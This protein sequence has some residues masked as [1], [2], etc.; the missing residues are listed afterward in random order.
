[1][2]KQSLLI[3]TLFFS[4]II[5]INTVCDINK[6]TNKKTECLKE[7]SVD[8]YCCFIKPLEDPTLPSKCYPYKIDKYFGN[9][10]INHNKHVY[11]ID[12][13]LGSTFMDSSWNR[14][15][16]D[17]QICGKKI[18]PD[19]NDDCNDNSTEDNSCCYYEG[20]DGLRE[21]YWLGIKYSGKVTRK[22][23]T[24]ICHAGNLKKLSL[25]LLS[26]LVILLF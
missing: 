20:E 3:L 10:N 6:E 1:M 24:F 5:K 8:E 21:C 4:F 7:R 2:K 16:E 17:R 26:I 22:G 15:L 25:F 12:C 23:Y 11:T 14:T 13:G 19:N 18:I 9:I